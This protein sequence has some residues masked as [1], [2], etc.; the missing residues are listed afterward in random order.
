[1][2]YALGRGVEHYDMPAVRQIVADAAGD[3]YRASALIGGIVRSV[4]YQM[5]TTPAPGD[6]VPEGQLVAE[7]AGR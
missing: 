7:G 4:P 3:D 2:T 5:R 6:D 1:M